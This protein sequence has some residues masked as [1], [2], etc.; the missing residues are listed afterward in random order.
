MHGAPAQRRG[1]DAGGDFSQRA[2]HQHRAHEVLEAHQ[3]RRSRVEHTNVSSEESRDYCRPAC[4]SPSA[5]S[6]SHVQKH[7]R[8]LRSYHATVEPWDVKA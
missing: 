1:V 7:A 4:S 5:C 3:P 8:G 2:G 6:N